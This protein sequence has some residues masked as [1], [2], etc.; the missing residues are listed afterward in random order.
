MIFWMVFFIVKSIER[1]FGMGYI[2]TKFIIIFIINLC[3][4]FTQWDLVVCFK[5]HN[6]ELWLESFDKFPLF[7]C[8]VG[9]FEFHCVCC[10]NGGCTSRCSSPSDA[11][12]F[13]PSNS[14]R[15]S[16]RWPWTHPCIIDVNDGCLSTGEGTT[17]MISE[18]QVEIEP[19]NSV[20]SALC[21]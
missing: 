11:Q 3:L 15:V 8:Q 20:M 18:F 19:A 16:D 12:R 17:K 14:F 21:S 13:R 6:I 1:C 2:S 4:K 7:C 10:D 5:L 9:S